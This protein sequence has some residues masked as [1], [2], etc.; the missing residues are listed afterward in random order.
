MSEQIDS[1]NLELNFL[2]VSTK[3]IYNIL[4]MVEREIILIALGNSKSI[5][6]ASRAL[7]IPR[8]TLFMKMKKLGIEGK[9]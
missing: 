8:T 5:T 1:L 7:K 2:I 4:E 3:G 6:A 9:R